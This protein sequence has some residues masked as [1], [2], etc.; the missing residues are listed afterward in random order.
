MRGALAGLRAISHG[1]MVLIS[2]VQKVPLYSEPMRTQRQPCAGARRQKT[3]L[4][5]MGL[6]PHKGKKN[7]TGGRVTSPPFFA[8]HLTKS[9][10][11]MFGV[12]PAGLGV[13][14]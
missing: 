4:I 8:H 3:L 9:G 2:A 5:V 1:A 7:G 14:C 11:R 10:L 12:C 13:G 6:M